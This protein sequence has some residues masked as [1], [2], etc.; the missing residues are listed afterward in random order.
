MSPQASE[1][2][3]KIKKKK[4]ELHQTKKFFHSKGN[5]PQHE[6]ATYCMGEDIFK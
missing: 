2:K 1:T 3:A 6:K 5:Y 4:N